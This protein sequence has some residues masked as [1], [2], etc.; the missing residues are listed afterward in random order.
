[1]IARTIITLV[2]F[3]IALSVGLSVMEQATERGIE[4]NMA[5]EPKHLCNGV[6]GCEDTSNSWED[7]VTCPGP[8][9]G[10]TPMLDLLFI[11]FGLGGGAVVL[12]WLTGRLD[13]PEEQS[14]DGLTVVQEQ[15]V[16]GDIETVLELEQRLDEEMEN[17]DD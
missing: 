13:P 15:Y 2:V 10:G 12:G 9:C 14:K 16:N 5:E 3:A 8:E 1:M 6:W 17:Q 4:G 7:I 11:S